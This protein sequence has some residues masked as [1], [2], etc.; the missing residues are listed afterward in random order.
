M[1]RGVDVAENGSDETTA[2]VGTVR[3]ALDTVRMRALPSTQNR[4]AAL[5]LASKVFYRPTTATWFL[6]PAH[7]A[8]PAAYAQRGDGRALRTMRRTGLIEVNM[9]AGPDSRGAYPVIMTDAGTDRYRS[10]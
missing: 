6:Q 10:R 7:S 1:S 5:I 8:D 3:G 4:M 9:P 2:K